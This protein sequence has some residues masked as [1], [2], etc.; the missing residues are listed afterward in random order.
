MY[1]F[2]GSH[3]PKLRNGFK[4]LL[5]Y[6][7]I[8]FDPDRF[9]GL[10][11]VLGILISLLVAILFELILLLNPI[12]FVA[13]F[14]ITYIIFVFGTYMVL[15]F[16]VESKANFVDKILPDALN[17]MAVNIRS[18]LTTDRAFL[19]A[20]RPEFGPLEVEIREA[21]KRIMSGEDVR[22]SLLKIPEKIKSV[23]LERTM[24]LIVEGIES[25]GELSRLL[26]ETAKDIERTK[27][28]QAEVKANVLMYVIFIFFAAGIGVPIIYG[29]STN[30]VDVLIKQA[31]D[32]GI[33]SLPSQSSLGISLTSFGQ[34]SISS[35]FLTMFSLLAML[36]TSIFAGMII[37]LIKDGKE[38]AGAKYIPMI[39][40][41][42][43]ILFFITK[44]LLT[45]FIVI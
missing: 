5:E 23:L 4:S 20:A 40:I 42:S 12:F 33:S 11:I 28:I 19:I 3:I 10:I 7:H 32:I 44:I 43:V 13:V 2:I 16:S 38:K 8:D 45:S 22:T 6:A 35:E 26:E 27:I 39:L 37:G 21:G 25:G 34:V 24:K 31:A 18:G 29:I 41:L 30:L 9:T 17:M 1:K 36:I 15:W 14:V